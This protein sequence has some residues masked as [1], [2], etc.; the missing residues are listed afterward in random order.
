M[1]TFG[2]EADILGIWLYIAES[3]SLGAADY[4]LEHFKELIRSLDH[5]PKRAMFHRN[6]NVLAW[7]ST[8]RST[9]S[10]IV[11]ST[12][13]A[14]ITSMFIASSMVDEMSRRPL[15]SVCSVDP[16]Y[17]SHLDLVPD[18]FVLRADG[19]RRSSG[20][21]HDGDI[22]L[23]IPVRIQGVAMRLFRG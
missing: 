9:S 2:A 6:W 3:D 22:S 18:R 14:K 5:S 17:L 7:M 15:N 1:N 8:C 23:A 10:P 21:C 19:D 11:S 16:K 4:V 13:S 20:G 12:M